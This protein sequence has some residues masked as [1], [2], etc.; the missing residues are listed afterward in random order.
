MTT[1]VQLTVLKCVRCSAFVPAQEEEVA[2]VCAPC[3]QGL[4]LTEAGLAAL[5][6]NWAAA[7]PGAPALRWL[8]FWVSRGTVRFAR[9]ESYRGSRAPD[10]LWNVPRR[11]YIPAFALPLPAMQTLGADLT[12]RQVA[13]KAGSPQ[14]ALSGCTLHLADARQAAEFIVLSIEAAQSDKLKRVDFT[15]QLE[16]PAL[17]LLPFAGEAEARNLALA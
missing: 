13:L 14:G 4:Q 16:A 5:T 15:L 2:W 17:W 3:G 7:R 8:P 12:R 10:A 6:I 9:R 11:F 1:S